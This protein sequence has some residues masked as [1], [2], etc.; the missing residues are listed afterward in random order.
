ME[1]I[2]VN[3]QFLSLN[4][5]SFEGWGRHRELI[6]SQLQFM[7]ESPYKLVLANPY[8]IDLKPGE[9][10]IYMSTFEADKLP[11]E[12]IGPA[13]KAVAIIV[14]DIWVKNVFINS[15]VTVPIYIIPEGVTD[16]TVWHPE[17][18]PFTF[19]HFDAT[20]YANR[21]GGDMVLDAFISVFGNMQDKVKLIMKGRNHHVAS[22]KKYNNVEYIFEDYNQAQMDDLWKKT[23]CF[24][25]PSRGEGFGLPPLEAMAHGIPTIV[26]RGSA[27]ETFSYY[28]IPLNVIGKITATY[29]GYTNFGK[30]DKPDSLKL[31][32][33]MLMVYQNYEKEKRNAEFNSSI[34]WQDYNFS[35]IAPK[36]AELI[37]AIISEDSKSS[38]SSEIINSTTSS[39][40]I[41]K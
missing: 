7:N 21:K 12:F 26:T 20:S 9:K 22:P 36:L 13:N 10:V 40:V 31:R 4:Y 2:K 28:A 8:K 15:G 14:P 5:K 39:E 37:N 18:K 1:K 17:P 23:N 29:D 27:M 41:I 35:N 34:I 24:V 33:L 25:F 6:E 3:A 11:D 32:E 16:N 19:L 38:I 30:W